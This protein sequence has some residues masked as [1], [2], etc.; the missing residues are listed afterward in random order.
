MFRVQV[1]DVLDYFNMLIILNTGDL[2][3]E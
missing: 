2:C 3:T 1:N